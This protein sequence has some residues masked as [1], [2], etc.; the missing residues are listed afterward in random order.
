MFQNY[1]P[2]L[3]KSLS[4]LYLANTCENPICILSMDFD[5][6]DKKSCHQMPTGT[7]KNHYQPVDT[8]ITEA[9]DRIV[10]S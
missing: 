7:I 3:M 9:L 6:R 8:S 4:D 1:Q 10:G 5:Q 2:A